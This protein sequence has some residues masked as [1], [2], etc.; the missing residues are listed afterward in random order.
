MS[1]VLRRFCKIHRYKE[2]EDH[3]LYESNKHFEEVE[4]YDHEITNREKPDRNQTTQ[5]D[6]NTYQDNSSK[7]ISKETERESE[8]TDELTHE[9]EPTDDD[10]DD[11]FY[12]VFAMKVKR[13][14]SDIA[15]E[16]S[17]TNHDNVWEEYHHDSHAECRIDISIDRSE[18]VMESR[19]EGKHPIEEEA[20]EIGTKY[21]D[22]DTSYKPETF[23]EWQIMTEK[24]L[25]EGFHIFHNEVSRCVYEPWFLLSRSKKYK[26]NNRDNDHKNPCRKNSISHWRQKSTLSK[27][28]RRNRQDMWCISSCHIF[29]MNER[30]I[31]EIYELQALKNSPFGRANLKCLEIIIQVR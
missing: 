14:V 27:S 9:V 6:H 21:V 18:I 10:T 7:Y 16:S 1:F 2:W 29:M 17:K 11:F 22:K 24:W 8:Y 30:I 3:R 4:W 15:K 31:D 28:M 5:P 26:S 23:L 19:E 13:K 20:I 12:D 25:K